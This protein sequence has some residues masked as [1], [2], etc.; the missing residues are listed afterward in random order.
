MNISREQWLEIEPLFNTALELDLERRTAWLVRLDDTHPDAAPMVRR[1]LATHERAERAREMETVPKL[2]PAPP[3]SSPFAPGERVGPYRLLHLIGQ[4]GMGE[5]W[6]AEQADGRVE[7]RV[8][9]KL[10][11]LPI[12]LESGGTLRAR[13]ALERDI[14]A[15]LAHAHIARLYDAGVTDAGQP[16]MAMEFVEG[17]SIAE[18]A[19]RNKL[20]IDARLALFRQ[21]L[22][23]TGHAHRHLVVHRDL[24]PAN[25][26]ID[27]QGQVKLLDFGIAKLIDADGAARAEADEAALTRADARVM[28]LRYA[29][30]EQI[31]GGAIS[32]ATDIYAL[33]V[34]LHELLAGLSPHR[35]LREGR[36]LTELARQQDEP[37]LPS[38]LP[39]T[40]AA[41]QERGTD[42]ARRVAR[43]LKGDLDAII[44]KALRRDPADRYLS[45]EQFDEDLMRHIERR[46]VQARRGTWRYL[47]GRFVL[48]H[49]WPI[50]TAAA[51]LVTLAGGLV[52][53][54]HER[55]IAVAER[56]RAERHFQSVRSL[57]NTFVFKVH[58]EIENLPGSL[59]AR[60]LLV[61]TAL[62]YL[63]GLAAESVDDRAL[64]VE[65]AS[66]Y[67]RIGEIK[68]DVYSSSLGENVTARANLEKARALLD[69]LNARYPD[70]IDVLRERRALGM[71]LARMAKDAGDAAAVSEI[72]STVV[73]AKRIAEL[74]GAKREDTRNVALALAEQAIT[75]AIMKSDYKAAMAPIA[76]AAARM[77]KLVAEDPGDTN[78]R[79]NLSGIYERASIIHEVAGD[80]DGLEKAVDYMK[81]AIALT[82]ALAKEQPSNTSHTSGLVKRNANLAD[83][84]AGQ[85]RLDEAL[86]VIER[87][88]TLSSALVAVE[89]SNAVH[90]TAYLR[91]LNVASNVLYNRKDYAATIKRGREGR[92]AFAALGAEVR[93]GL[94]TRANH[95][96]VTAYLGAAL[97]DQAVAAGA[98]AMP[99]ERKAAQLREARALLVEARDFRLELV[100]RDVDAVAARRTAD[101]IAAEI[102]DCDAVLARLAKS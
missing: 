44:L 26:L 30:P 93:E 97:K 31:G 1:L 4:G 59:K 35:A 11:L 102:A 23:A 58:D 50:A 70:Q 45:V 41:A 60:Q 36:P 80:K 86:P 55:R 66:A 42:A 17:E 47:A 82:E 34:I 15:R 53:A 65:V 10:P 72:D 52:M 38:T 18:Y 73:M 63:D 46:P 69:A 71:V 100:R 37:V 92:A 25:I 2:A 57:A 83:S 12:H 79:L 96:G 51:A 6:L 89:P 14:L 5:V 76:Q 90:A 85:G 94:A 64:A 74:P 8:A 49:K 43:R 20:T 95:A 33:G 24:K 16:Y 61:G 3:A 99:R 91:T 32:T 68:G 56:Q 67:R 48:R 77:E 78:A 84:L 54:E 19:A 13:F 7:R 9:L 27:A 28:T 40:A 87:A 75:T 98:S 29:A 88:V 22:A 21:V 62:E 101:A 39:I 81:K